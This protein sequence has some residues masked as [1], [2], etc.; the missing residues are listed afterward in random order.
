MA[1]RGVT[2]RGLIFIFLSLIIISTS[3]SVVADDH[4]FYRQESKPNNFPPIISLENI[5]RRKKQVSQPKRWQSLEWFNFAR[6]SK[7]YEEKSNFVIQ[8]S[9]QRKLSRKVRQ[10]QSNIL[11]SLKNIKHGLEE[12]FDTTYRPWTMERKLHRPNTGFSWTT[13]LVF[14]NVIFYGLQM[15]YPA[16][17]R[18]GTKRSDLILRGKELH[19]LFTPVFLHGMYKPI[20]LEFHPS[21]FTT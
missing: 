1:I 4:S 12:S 9:D 2:H 16:I 18:L 3:S 6:A 8:S 10:V 15:L 20:H 14:A 5:F 21:Y 11:Q 13:S 17:T 7:K 19:R